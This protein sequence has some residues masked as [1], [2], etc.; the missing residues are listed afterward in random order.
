MMFTV[1]VESL[2][3][4]ESVPRHIKDT[5]KYTDLMEPTL[6]YRLTKQGS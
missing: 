3:V 2:R 4:D 5:G 1:P 6:R